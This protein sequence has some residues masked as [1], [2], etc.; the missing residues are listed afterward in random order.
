[1]RVVDRP[2]RRG[3][4]EEVVDRRG[5]LEGALVAVPHD[6]RRS[7]SGWRRGRARRGRSP[8]A[9]CGCAAGRGANGRCGRPPARAPDRCRTRPPARPRTGSNR[10]CRA[11][12]ARGCP[13]CAP[14]RRCSASRASNRPRSAA[15]LAAGAIGIAAPA[16]IGVGEIGLVLP[17]CARR[18]A[19]AARRHRRPA[20][21]RRRGSRRAARPRPGDAPAA[22]SARAVG[23]R[24]GRRAGS[25]PAARRAPRRRATA[26]SNRSI[27]PGKASRKKPEMRS[28]TSTRGRS[29]TEAG[30]ISKPVTRPL[31]PS[32]TG[33]TPISA[34]A[35]AMSS[36]PVRMFAVPQ[37]DSASRAG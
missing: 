11:D 14:R 22:S 25:S 15:A 24:R 13:G 32:Q 5:D 10:R 9:A 35:C 34:S 19:P 8:R 6:A 1:M 30:R 31:A 21:S 37:A 3:E 4:G 12:R 7:I 36:P 33:R 20:S 2:R 27:R 29:S 23:A 18:S 28:V 26:L 17:R 16:E